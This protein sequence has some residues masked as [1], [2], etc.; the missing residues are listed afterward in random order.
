MLSHGRLLAQHDRVRPVEDGVRHV[1]GFGAGRDEALDHR[2]QHLSRRDDRLCRPVRERDE[3]LLQHRDA[4]D[5]DLDPEVAARDHDAVRGVDDLLE[6]LGRGGCLDLRDHGKPARPRRSEVD[7][8][9]DERHADEVDAHREPGTQ[10]VLILRRH[11]RQ[12]DARR[13]Q[14]DP[15]AG[16]DVAS[17]DDPAASVLQDL[18]LHDAVREEHRVARAHG[19]RQRE[20]DYVAGACT[21]RVS[22]PQ[23]RAR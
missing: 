17:D 7:R 5:R 16:R 6:M 23:L 10:V 9:A 2:P 3:P 12:V 8:T 1:G 19:R 14:V 22:E 15:L 4:L 20:C 21:Y 13:R 11:G 18:E